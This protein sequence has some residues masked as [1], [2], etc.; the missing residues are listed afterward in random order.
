MNVSPFVS[1]RLAV[2]LAGVLSLAALFTFGA[3]PVLRWNPTSTNAW[4]ATSLTWLD[5]TNGA[6]AWQPGSEAQFTG[7]SFIDADLSV[8]SGASVV[9]L[10]DPRIL[11]KMPP[12]MP[13]APPPKVPRC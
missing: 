3:P 10:G 4:D 11:P 6:S 7:S 5:A 13:A 9:T 12:G 2:R 8:A 1:S